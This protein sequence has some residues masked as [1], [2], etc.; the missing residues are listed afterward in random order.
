[1]KSHRTARKGLRAR[2]TLA[3]ILIAGCL[4]APA[5]AA[6][7]AKHG[8]RPNTAVR[9]NVYV[10]PSPDTATRQGQRWLAA[11]GGA[12]ELRSLDARTTAKATIPSLPDVVARYTGASAA[13][14]AYPHPISDSPVAPGG[15]RANA[16]SAI[17]LSLTSALAGA[18]G[19]LL[20]Q[21]TRLVERARR[22]RC[23][24]P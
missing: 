5:A 1:V 21:R 13:D 23:R 17:V 7:S 22:A 9:A 14:R 19:V 3:A 10:P 15:G 18:A 12:R 24:K 16:W 4:L 8:G 11:H 20:V 2:W 6:P